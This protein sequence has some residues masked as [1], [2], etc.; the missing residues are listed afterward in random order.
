MGD[1]KLFKIIIEETVSDTFEIY[2]EDIDTAMEIAE[3]NY[4]AGEIVL[5]P[6]YVAERKMHITDTDTGFELGWV[7]F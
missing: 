1:V 4:K 6:G 2:A 5:S 3:R 7:E